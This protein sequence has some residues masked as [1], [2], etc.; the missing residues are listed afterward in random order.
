MGQQGC[1]APPA[2]TPSMPGRLAE[3][4]RAATAL[5][6]CRASVDRL[7]DGVEIEAGRQ[8]QVLVAA[9][10]GDVGRLAVEIAAV[11]RVD[12]DLLGDGGRQR[13][14]RRPDPARSSKLD[15]RIGAEGRRLRRWPSALTGDRPGA[16]PRRASGSSERASARASA[17][18]PSLLL[19][20]LRRSPPTQPI[21]DALAPSAAGRRCRRAG[22]GGIRRGW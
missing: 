21:S 14:K 5:S 22:S 19:D 11:E 20:R 18:A 10:G 4:Q 7:A 12:L 1:R 13:P 2:V 3:G 6:V 9:E 17:E 8:G 15:A 16:P